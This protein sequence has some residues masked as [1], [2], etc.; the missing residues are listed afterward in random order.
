MTDDAPL[1]RETTQ[2]VRYW[3]QTHA[4][5]Y[6]N[7]TSLAEGCGDALCL[8]GYPPHCVIPEEVYAM[9]LDFFGEA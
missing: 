5:E 6:D 7:P 1:S 9:A 2:R 3:M 4:D 8:A